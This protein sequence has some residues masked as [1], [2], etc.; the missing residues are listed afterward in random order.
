MEVR[1]RKV[2]VIHRGINLCRVRRSSAPTYFGLRHLHPNN[3]PNRYRIIDIL[4][5]IALKR[6]SIH[7]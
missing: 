3:V 5:H 7:P 2:T 1:Q 6:D 4:V